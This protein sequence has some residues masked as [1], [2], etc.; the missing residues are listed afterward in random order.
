MNAERVF[1]L[2]VD[3]VCSK[4]YVYEDYAK[5]RILCPECEGKKKVVLHMGNAYDN[6]E[7]TECS[8]CV[9]SGIVEFNVKVWRD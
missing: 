2:M 1:E 5:L 3:K 9:G 4:N 8:N 6:T 7:F